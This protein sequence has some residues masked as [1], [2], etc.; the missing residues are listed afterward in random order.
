MKTMLMLAGALSAG[1]AFGTGDLK[2]EWENGRRAETLDWFRREMFGYAPDRPADERFDADGVSFANG[3]VKIRIHKK[4]PAGASAANPAPAFILLDHYNGAARPDGLWHRAGTPTNDIVARGYAYININLNDIA[5]NA[6]D[7]TWSNGVHR[8]YGAGKPDDWGTLSAWAWGVSRVMDWIEHQPELDASRVGVIGHSRGGK[9][10]LWAA[11]QD[12]RI[13]LAVPNG[14][15]TGGARLLSMDL[16]DAEPLD[17]MLGGSIRF[18]YCGNLQKYFART[19]SLPHDADDLLRLVCPRLV[20]SP[21]LRPLARLRPAGPRGRSVPR[22]GQLVQR[23][24]RRLH[25]A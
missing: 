15:G 6:Y 5:L 25:A 21:R 2:T 16:S 23:G 10:A 9:T 18:W 13:A 11:A 4:L 3:A 12:E 7:E 20:Y 24:L 22:A 14:S 19:K 8:L 1:L 17:W